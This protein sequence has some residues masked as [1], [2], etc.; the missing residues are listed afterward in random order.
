MM[1]SREL[2]EKAHAAGLAAGNAAVPVPMV[3]G[4]AT[5]LFSNEIDRSKP[6]YHVPDGVCGFAWV[7]IHPNRGE[8]VRYLKANRIG[9]PGYPKGYSVSVHL[10]GQ[11]MQRKEAYAGAFARVLSAAGID[12]YAESRID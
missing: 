10:Y 1:N 8:F 11:S 2:Y 3:V 4:Q 9:R 7:S 5:G 12:A 6:M